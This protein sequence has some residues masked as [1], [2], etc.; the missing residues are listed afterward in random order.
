ML[1]AVTIVSAQARADAERYVALGADPARVH[2]T[3]NL[4]FDTQTGPSLTEGSEA[5]RRRFGGDRLILVAGSTRSG[6][7]PV[8]LEAFSILR[9]RF[10]AALLVLA[11][12]HPERAQEIAEMCTRRGLGVD[13][14]SQSADIELKNPVYLVDTM[15]DLMRFYAAADVAFV[16][17]SLVNAG[18]HNLLEPASLGKPVITGPHTFNFA[19]VVD[20]LTESG[21]LLVVRNAEEL[22]RA[23]GELFVDGNRRF[24][25]GEAGRGIFRHHR[26]ASSDIV[27]LIRPLLRKT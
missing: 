2:V 18:G 22:A 25:C 10:P 24:Q 3:G 20:L 14:H 13:R 6:E 9:G 15:G 8:V 17:G 7:E 12:R 26:G 19:T 21:A 1:H 27:T 4:K 11:P 16:G 5:L 23:V